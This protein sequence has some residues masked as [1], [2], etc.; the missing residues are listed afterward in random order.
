MVARGRVV[1]VKT[2]R[3]RVVFQRKLPFSVRWLFLLLTGS[4]ACD[5]WSSAK[6][7]G[8]M[9]FAV[10]LCYHRSL[11]T[12][13]PVITWFLVYIA[14]FL[15]NGLFLPEEYL[16]EFFIRLF[17]LVQSI[18]FLWIGSDILKD[19]KIARKA[20]IAYCVAS[21]IPAIGLVLSLPGFSVSGD[22]G[23]TRASAIGVAPTS[24]ALGLVMLLGL[25][26]SL[27]HKRLIA[28][29]VTTGSMLA[30]AAAI[31]Y[32]GSRSAVLMSMIGLLLYLMPYLN[33]RWRVPH[34][35]VGAIAIAGLTY[36]AATTPVFSDRWRE[37]SEGGDTS[38][39]DMIFETAAEM[40][41]ER[42][43][44]GWQPVQFEYELGQRTGARS[45]RAAHNMYLH[46][47]MEVGI[48][49]AVPFLV[50]LWLCG[51]SAWKSR[52]LNLGLLPAGL[53][54]AVLA[55]GIGSNT[56]YYKTLWFVLAVAAS[57]G[58]Q[59]K[60]QGIILATRVG[61]NPIMKPPRNLDSAISGV[62]SNLGSQRRLRP[63]S[64]R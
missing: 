12:I 54:L 8:I 56:I 33:R 18:F 52:N 31:V 2:A 1:F 47:L 51:K 45:V 22:V 55:S 50:G 53:F 30:L 25:W 10:Y 13:T 38:G 62:V 19:E 3:S 48:I 39:R 29:V 58:G 32:T 11:P 41:S 46:L 20:V 15:L 26:L 14:V 28:T 63:S 36:I 34:I 44:F 60:Q 5:V 37:F 6:L 17:T 40:I 35:I 21:L 9:F 61:E 49:G 64:S 27:P 59:T 24:L 16:G 7:F 4:I 57:A 43:L 42:P 23:I